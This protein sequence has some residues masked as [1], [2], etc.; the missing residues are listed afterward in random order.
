[1][2]SSPELLVRITTESLRVKKTT[3]LTSIDLFAGAGGTALGLEHAGIRHLALNEWDKH[4]AATL[5]LNR[6]DW[7]VIEG[8]I[9]GVDFLAIRVKWI[10]LKVVSVSGV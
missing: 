6:P 3:S 5:R 1:M 9:A 7:N 2:I 10:L 8:D 4:A